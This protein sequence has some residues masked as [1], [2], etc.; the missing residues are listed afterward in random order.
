MTNI[1]HMVR[2]SKVC[3]PLDLKKFI[4][5]DSS[6]L[7]L[8]LLQVKMFFGVHVFCTRFSL[9]YDY[10]FVGWTSLAK[11]AHLEYEFVLKDFSLIVSAC[12]TI[13][14]SHAEIVIGKEV[15]S[16]GA[17]LVVLANRWLH[18]T[19]FH[20]LLWDIVGCIWSARCFNH[21]SFFR[22]LFSD[23]ILYS[24][25]TFSMST[26]FCLSVILLLIWSCLWTTISIS[27]VYKEVHQLLLSF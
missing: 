22:Y 5:C 3:Y 13:S 1:F 21:F 2:S 8:F 11:A 9:L 7:V 10:S 26:V 17:I 24:S 25:R 27:N 12:K 20:L 16:F 19:A 15:N 4:F 6:N 14:M 18:Q 23:V